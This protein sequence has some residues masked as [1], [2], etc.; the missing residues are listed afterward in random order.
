M[1]QH[2][3]LHVCECSTLQGAATA[4]WLL[5]LSLGGDGGS[6]TELPVQT[7]NSWKPTVT[8]GALCLTEEDRLE[9]RGR[10]T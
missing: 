6:L 5:L 1:A 9:E 2:I 10:S 4:A 8:T 3:W 7:L